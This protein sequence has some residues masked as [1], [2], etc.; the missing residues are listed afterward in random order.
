MCHYPMPAY[1]LQ[2]E[3]SMQTVKFIKVAAGLYRLAKPQ[4]KHC[5]LISGRVHHLTATKVMLIEGMEIEL[6]G[7]LKGLCAVYEAV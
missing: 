3:I 1:L 2:L 7:T 4:A 6:L 5:D